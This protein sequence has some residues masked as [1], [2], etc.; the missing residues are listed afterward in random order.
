MY[1][2]SLLA[3]ENEMKQKAQEAEAEVLATIGMYR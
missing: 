2:A 1:V 3:A